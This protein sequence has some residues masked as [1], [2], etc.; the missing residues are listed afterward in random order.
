MK[1]HGYIHGYT[2]FFIL[3]SIMVYPKGKPLWGSQEKT[4]RKAHQIPCQGWVIIAYLQSQKFHH[5]VVKRLGSGARVEFSLYYFLPVW[6]WICHPNS[7][8]LSFY[9]SKMGLTIVT[10][11]GL[12]RELTVLMIIISILEMYF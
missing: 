6:F 1:W 9:I 7:Q 8:C 10:N 4:V 12:I 5:T 3:F 2:F 11:T